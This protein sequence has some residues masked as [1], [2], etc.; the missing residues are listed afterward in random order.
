[1]Y[2]KSWFALFQGTYTI[3]A[4][5]D[6]EEQEEYDAT[7]II[8]IAVSMRKLLT[9]SVWPTQCEQTIGFKNT[10]PTLQLRC[11]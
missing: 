6:V 2:G 1:M 7:K 4:R 8:F 3:H 9:H 11:F 5:L 10:P